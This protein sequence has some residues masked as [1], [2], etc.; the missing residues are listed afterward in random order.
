MTAGHK[1]G[2]A[3]V[4]LVNEA[5]GELK[6]HE[7]TRMWIQRLD[8]LVGVLEGG[9]EEGGERSGEG[10]GGIAERGDSVS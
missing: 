9:F 3:T 10:G 5:N 2:A 1:A 4:L 8:E 7:H 6:G